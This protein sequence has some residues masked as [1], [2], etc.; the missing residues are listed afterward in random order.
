[1]SAVIEILL[2]CFLK[3]KN[4]KRRKL[5]IEQFKPFSHTASGRHVLLFK[6]FCSAV[7]FFKIKSQIY[8]ESR[9]WTTQQGTSTSIVMP[10][11]KFSQQDR[12]RRISSGPWL[13]WLSGLDIV[14]ETERSLVWVP[15][16]T[17]ACV[18]GRV[19]SWGC[20]RGNQLMFLSLSFFL[21]SPLSKSK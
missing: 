7:W 14:L 20:V 5:S 3:G 2:N 17:Q 1:M 16:R 6:F 19:P 21:P 9:G 10:I 4:P 13:V 15:V 12:G 8:E 11:D 18:V